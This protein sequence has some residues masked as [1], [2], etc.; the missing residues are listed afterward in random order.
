MDFRKLLLAGAA[1]M[2]AAGATQAAQSGNAA[3]QRP[4]AAD[5]LAPDEFEFLEEIQGERALA[6]ARA[7]NE[8]TLGALQSD[9]RYQQY[10]DR[11]LEIL[12][13]RDRIPFVAIRP[14]GLYNFWQD[15]DH[16][17]GILRRTT[18]ASYRTANPQWETVLDIDALARAENANWVYQGM[19]CL[20]PDQRRCLVILSNGGRDANFVREFDLVAGRFV[21]GGFSLP[22]G[23]QNVAWVDENTILVARDFGEGTMSTSGYPITIAACAAVRRSPRPR[24][25]S[26]GARKT[27]ASSRWFCAMPRA[28]SMR[29]A[30]AA[31]SASSRASGRSSGRAE[32]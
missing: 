16:V 5:P 24:S 32:T 3:A 31:A 12:Q 13:A 9:P 21:E 19:T 4:A 10:Y 26:A 30:S 8:R 2:T 14:S 6:W 17:R 1:A 15:Q 11:A 23:K 25:C 27:C 29:P 22:E 18:L 28:G 20:P 7:E